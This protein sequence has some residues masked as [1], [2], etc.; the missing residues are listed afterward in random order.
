MIEER[1]RAALKDA[2]R[3]RDAV[4]TAALRSALAAIGNAT[5]VPSVPLD[6]SAGSE[7]VAGAAVGLGAA[8]VPR[9]S[10]TEHDVAAIVRTEID[11]RLAAA[12]QVPAS[13]ER[14]RAEAA[15]LTAHL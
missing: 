14:L 5:A 4:A 10:L 3:S 8:E 11:E 1:L 13:A 6:A 7:H 2:M 12:E 9:R 15:V